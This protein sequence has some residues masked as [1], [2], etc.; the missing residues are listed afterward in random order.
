MKIFVRIMNLIVLCGCM[1]TIAMEQYLLFHKATQSDVASLLKVINEQA[2]EDSA[3]IVILPKKFR[4]GALES[5]IAKNRVYCV[6]KSE[7]DEVIAFKKLFI[8]DDAEEHQ[9]ITHDEIRCHGEKSNVV[10]VHMIYNSGQATSFFPSFNADD[11]VSIY[12]GGDYTVPDYRN[13]KVNSSLVKYAFEDIKNDVV[14]A[15]QS[16][17]APNIVLLYGLTTTNSGE[18][19]DENSIDRTPSIIRAF[20]PFVKEIA[21]QTNHSKDI[22]LY[23]SR[24][25]AYMPTF[26]ADSTVCKPLPDKHAIQGYGNVLLFQLVKK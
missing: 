15:V 11:S 8:I 7:S 16:K 26:D 10:D 25:I 6:T 1:S 4:Q 13:Q 21:A 5:D 3:K 9:K 12:F 14:K 18:G 22:I 19:E 20:K 2:I 17:K 24:Y 23:H